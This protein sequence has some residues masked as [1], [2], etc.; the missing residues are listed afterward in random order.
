MTQDLPSGRDVWDLRKERGR[1]ENTREGNRSTPACGLRLFFRSF[2]PFLFSLPPHSI[3]RLV[4]FSIVFFCFVCMFVF[5][6]EPPKNKQKT[7]QKGEVILFVFFIYFVYSHHII[8]SCVCLCEAL[9][10]FYIPHTGHAQW[11]VLRPVCPYPVLFCLL[12]LPSASLS[13]FLCLSDYLTF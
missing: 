6:T 8:F 13:S 1:N 11:R 9:H 2:P 3:P 12:C 4:S 7:K 5:R 10:S